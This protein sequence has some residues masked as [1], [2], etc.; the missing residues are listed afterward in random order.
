MRADST[1]A[2]SRCTFSSV[3]TTNEILSRVRRLAA[4]SQ[5]DSE[6]AA[7]GADELRVETLQAIAD[8]APDAVA[9]AQAALRT[10]E[11]DIGGR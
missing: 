4:L 2:Q 6:A 9:L 1:F 3:T 5:A 7:A 11:Q 10:V 8:G